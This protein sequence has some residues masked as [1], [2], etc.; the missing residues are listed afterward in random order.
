MWGVRQG[1]EQTDTE[2]RKGPYKDAVGA[3]QREEL[4]G[5]DL[6]LLGE[7]Q[8]LLQVNGVVLPSTGRSSSL[9]PL[10]CREKNRG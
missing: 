3:V 7:Q 1:A 2:K 6:A 10:P 4:K 9:L 5:T 8:E